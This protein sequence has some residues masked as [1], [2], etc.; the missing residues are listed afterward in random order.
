MEE[1]TDEKIVGRKIT[2]DLPLKYVNIID[3]HCR[4]TLLTRRKWFYDAMVDKLL[5]DNLISE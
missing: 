2:I 5:K 3:N 4:K 1:E